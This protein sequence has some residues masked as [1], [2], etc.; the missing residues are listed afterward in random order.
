MVPASGSSGYLARLD[1]TWT[2]VYSHV[3]PAPVSAL[4]FTDGSVVLGVTAGEALD[5]GCGTLAATSGGSTFVTRLDGTG[6]CVFGKSLPAPGLSV[7]LDPMGRLVMSGLVGAVP[8]DLGGGPMAPV[9]SRDLVLGELDAAGNFLW[10]KRFGGVTFT[11][12]AVSTSSAGDVYLRTGWSGSAS[13]GGGPIS[14]A[15]NDTV[16]AS[17][18]ASGAYRWARDFPIA[19][20]YQAG[21]DGCGA[22]VVASIDPAF[23]PGCGVLASAPGLWTQVAVARFAP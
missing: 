13:L 12:P 4:A 18:S 8:V 6:S 22:L 5:L 14:A 16:V 2:C 1:S 20:V 15:S 19:G 7:A 21:I 9:G 3:L 10:S 23:D 17:F 11:S